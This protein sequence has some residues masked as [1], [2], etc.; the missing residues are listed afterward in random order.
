MKTGRYVQGP[1]RMPQPDVVIEPPFAEPE[2]PVDAL[3]PAPPLPELSGKKKL[4]PN[5]VGA[6]ATVLVSTARRAKE[7]MVER[8]FTE[9]EGG[10]GDS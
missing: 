5:G 7:E 4:E 9:R 3:P 10:R 1:V 6:A 8:I 2:L